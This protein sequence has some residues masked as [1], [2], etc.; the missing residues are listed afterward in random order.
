MADRLHHKVRVLVAENFD[1]IHIGLRALFKNHIAVDLVAETGDIANLFPLL[2]EHRSDAALIDWQ[3]SECN[4]PSTF[5][6]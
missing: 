3:L 6:N 1:L 2:T 5:A 4:V